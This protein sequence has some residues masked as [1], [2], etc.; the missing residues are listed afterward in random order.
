MIPHKNLETLIRVMA[1][2]KKNK[3][4]LPQRLLVSG[5]SGNASDSVKKLIK[6]NQLEDNVTLTGFIKNEER[7]TLYQHC[8]A[9]LFPSIFE[10]FGIPPIEAM[11]FGA[12]VITTDRTSI[13]EVTQGK[14]NYVE[15]PFDVNAWIRVME[16]PVRRN[17]EFDFSKYD[18]QYLAEKY[19]DFLQDNFKER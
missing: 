4:H 15:D 19:M 12:T 11:A 8:R 16:S 7:N 17:D 6:E 10:G 1:E 14:A 2:L 9:F 18:R 13:P 3:S 5:I